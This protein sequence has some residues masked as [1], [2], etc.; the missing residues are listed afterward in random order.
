MNGDDAQQSLPNSS[1]HSLTGE[2][3]HRAAACLALSGTIFIIDLQL[4][5]GVAG[6]VPYVLVVL[7]A[8]GLPEERHTLFFAL[9]VSLLTMLGYVLSQPGSPSWMVIANRLLALFVIWAST[10]LGLRHQRAMTLLHESEARFASLARHTPLVVWRANVAG[11][12]QSVSAGWQRSI[13]DVPSVSGAINWQQKIHPNENASVV[14]RYREALTKSD[15][16]QIEC[17]LYTEPAG[18]RWILL[19]GSPYHDRVGKL[20]GYLGT[21][22]DINDRVVAERRYRASEARYRAITE[23]LLIGIALCDSQGRI[24]ATNQTMSRLFSYTT[25]EFKERRICELLVEP[26]CRLSPDCLRRFHVDNLDG[27]HAQES[28]GRRRDGYRFPLELSFA[29]Y[30]EGDIRHYIAA[31]RDLSRQKATEA[32]LNDFRAR[33]QYRDK[34]ATIGRLAAGLVHEI[35]NPL[36][37]ISGLLQNVRHGLKSG[38]AHSSN[39]IATQLD[40]VAHNLER[41]V[42]VTRDISAFAEITPSKRTLINLNELIDRT[43]RLVGYENST[44]AIHICARLDHSL[45]AVR[46]AADHI[47]QMLLH[48]LQNSVDACQRS[49]R[50]PQIV[51]ESVRESDSAVVRIIDNGCGMPADRTAMTNEPFLHGQ[52]ADSGLG[53]GLALCHALVAEYGGDLRIDSDPDCGTTVTIHLPFDGTQ[54][55]AATRSTMGLVT[56][57]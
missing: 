3:Q 49:P 37:A 39:R 42:N 55:P 21:L 26:T 2:T 5:L 47:V 24:T 53:I 44:A 10:I 57:H 33:Q 7:L 28:I 31:I 50:P 30:Y 15:T 52:T 46:L 11:E 1:Q 45:P 56:R 17:R 54:E 6:G 38:K 32:T 25:E 51:V 8:L 43:C 27:A 20:L 13:G 14:A 23:N 12:W 48:L 16:F 19:Q 41:I 22:I 40:E 18:Y 4:P 36:S 34:M 29:T 9:F 35:G